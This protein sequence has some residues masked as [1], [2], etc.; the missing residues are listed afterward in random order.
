MKKPS[1]VLLKR[2]LVETIF[3]VEMLQI[4]LVIHELITYL[5]E[6]QKHCLIVLRVIKLP[7]EGQ[8]VGVRNTDLLLLKGQ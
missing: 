4:W 2:F 1:L 5:V 8:P 3:P 7:L 6:Q